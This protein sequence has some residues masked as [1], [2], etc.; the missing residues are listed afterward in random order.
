MQRKTW[1]NHKVVK[2]NCI[3]AVNDALHEVD[4]YTKRPLSIT[5]MEVGLQCKKKESVY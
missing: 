2:D 3:Q 1:Y 5:H 4:L